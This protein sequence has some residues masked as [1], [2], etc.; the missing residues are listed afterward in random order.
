MRR[1]DEL[2]EG[3]RLDV[4]KPHEQREYVALLERELAG[5]ADTIP[6][7][8]DLVA[9]GEVLGRRVREL[10][11]DW[12]TRQPNPKPSWLVSWDDL[13]E[14]EREVYREIGLGIAAMF[15]HVPSVEAATSEQPRAP[16]R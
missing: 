11:V 12:A 15:G 3:H 1:L 13:S 16:S 2:R 9:L 5:K 14:S 7:P 4:L 6:P 10:W 8:F